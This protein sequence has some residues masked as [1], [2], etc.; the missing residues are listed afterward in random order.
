MSNRRTTN[1]HS[2]IPNGTSEEID[3][4]ESDD[5]M[6]NV[7]KVLKKR[8]VMSDS[9]SVT[10]NSDSEQELSENTSKS[11]KKKKMHWIKR[12]FVPPPS[13][14]TGSFPPP[15]IDSEPEPID[16]FCSMFGK[17]SFNILKDQSNL[18]S[19]QTNPN[20]PANISDTEIRQFIGILII[21]GVYSFP[22]QRFYWMDSTRIQSI[23]SVMSRD[24]FLSIKKCFH[25]VDNT[26]K[27]DQND[28][29]YDRAFKVRPLLNIVKENFR[30]IPK[31]E[32]L[33]VDEQIIP[34]K[35]KSVMKQ[36]MPNKPNRWGYKM[37]LLA[38]GESGLCYDFVL[39]TGKS[40]STE[41]GFCTDITLT[42]CETV[43]PMMNHKVYYDNYFTTIRLQV[44][45]KK[46]GIFSVGTVRANRLPDLTMKD[47]KQLKQEGL[48]ATDYRI[49][50]VD[51]VELCVTWAF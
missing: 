21:S 6:Q 47:E 13:P 10:E 22:Q 29:N 18:Y 1:I 15:P 20:R 35:G 37:F 19:V 7:R 50:Y 14:F 49:T 48:V 27:P 11:K 16:Y 32:N 8:L 41:Y 31:E 45:L 24:R 4:S 43:P 12:S 44:E 26:N 3:T 51:G 39:Y 33:C 46:L 34:F 38:G 42:L 23:A 5:E 9:S 28:P 17:E 25:V 36:H 40:N 30:K 2:T